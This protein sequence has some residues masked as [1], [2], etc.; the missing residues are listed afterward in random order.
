MEVTTVKK[1]NANLL[2]PGTDIGRLTI[3]T[4]KALEIMKTEKLFM[5][6]PKQPKEKKETKKKPVP[7]RKY[8]LKTKKPG[9]TK[10][11]RIRGMR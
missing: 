4:E 3:Y 8:S 7:N 6:N 1:L 10:G 11:F 2:A 5:V 9:K